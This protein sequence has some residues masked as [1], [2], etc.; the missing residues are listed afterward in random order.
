MSL[1]CDLSALKE[2]VGGLGGG[3]PSTNLSRGSGAVESDGEENHVVGRGGDRRSDGA[4]DETPSHPPKTPPPNRSP[5]ASTSQ[6]MNGMARM[7]QQPGLHSL[8]ALRPPPFIED[9]EPVREV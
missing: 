2:V 3:N 7:A 8:S 1:V 6:H 5:R 9:L 4:D